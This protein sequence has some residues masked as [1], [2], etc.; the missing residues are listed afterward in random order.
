MSAPQQ[1]D[2]SVDLV[3]LSRHYGE[4]IT[5]GVTQLTIAEQQR[6]QAQADN[7]NMARALSAAQ[8]RVAELEAEQAAWEEEKADLTARLAAAEAQQ[9]LPGSG[10]A[11]PPAGDPQ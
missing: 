10:S 2:V 1:P 11:E 8:T 9:P 7:V 3:R 6:D 4:L 5:S